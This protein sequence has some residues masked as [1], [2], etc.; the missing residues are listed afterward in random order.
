MK[1]FFAEQIVWIIIGITQ[2]SIFEA[3]WKFDNRDAQPYF[4]S[5]NVRTF[6]RS[7]FVRID[8]HS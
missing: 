7:T 6:K 3:L 2:I 8:G 5:I 4:G 1:N